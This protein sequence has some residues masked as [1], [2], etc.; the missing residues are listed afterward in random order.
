MQVKCTICGGTSD[1]TKAHK[2]YPKLAK[3]T[4]YTYIC[5]RCSIQVQAEMQKHQLFRK[6]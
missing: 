6:K 1:L 5:E 3:N 2:D 4:N